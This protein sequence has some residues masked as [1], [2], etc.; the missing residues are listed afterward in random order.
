VKGLEKVTT[1]AYEAVRKEFGSKP[2]WK[3]C[4]QENLKHTV[5]LTVSQL[6]SRA[7]L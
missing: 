5:G 7:L 4:M 2:D 1:E 3:V 6:S